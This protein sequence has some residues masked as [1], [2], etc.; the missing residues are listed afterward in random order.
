VRSGTLTLVTA[1]DVQVH[2]R[3]VAVARRFPTLDDRFLIADAHA[4]HV[5]L[6]AADPGTGTS[7]ELWLRTPERASERTLAAALAQP[8]FDRLAVARRS[9]VER[10]L[11]SDPLARG[12]LALL[13]AGAVV[14]LALVVIALT[15]VVVA[16]RRDDDATLL[17]LE[18]DGATPGE[19]RGMLLVRA[20]G[21]VLC[22]APLGV[23][24][25][26]VLARAVTSLVA[27]TATAVAPVPPLA[28][29]TGPGGAVLGVL[30][31][32]AVGALAAALAASRLLREPL[33][34]VPESVGS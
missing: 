14:A 15:L 1:G 5:A 7:N 9:A 31:A 26:L 4:L 24:T 32:L 21:L 30:V 19:L 25:G 27:V 13:L 23:V 16:D 34:P 28:A 20:L 12:A 29:V 10:A 3:V 17:A 18:A 6:D 22:A 8:P 11:R 33:P 2:A